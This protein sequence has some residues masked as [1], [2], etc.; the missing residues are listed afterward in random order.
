[1][2]AGF[3]VTEILIV[4]RFMET[5]FQYV[6][7]VMRLGLYIITVRVWPMFF[8]VQFRKE[9]LSKYLLPFAIMSGL[10]ARC[11]LPMKL[12]WMLQACNW[13]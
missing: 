12:Q 13:R 5:K 1:M 6:F 9:G 2:P 11:V 7:N 10:V 4:T 3:E 8:S